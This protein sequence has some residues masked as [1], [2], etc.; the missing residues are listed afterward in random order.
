MKMSKKENLR[1]NREKMI[2]ILENA[3]ENMDDEEFN[4]NFRRDHL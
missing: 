3:I 1:E 2:K 4:K